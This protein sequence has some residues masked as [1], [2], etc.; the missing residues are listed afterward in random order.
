MALA[1]M[2]PL[3]VRV[4]LDL[5]LS[6]GFDAAKLGVASLCHSAVE[7][8]PRSTNDSPCENL[9]SQGFKGSQRSAMCLRLSSRRV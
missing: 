3:V 6:F 1:L 9:G 2:L 4:L 7:A 5:V 8:L